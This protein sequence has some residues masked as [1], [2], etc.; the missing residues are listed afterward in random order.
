MALNYLNIPY[1]LTDPFSFPLT[2]FLS[3]WK[4]EANEHYSC[5]HATGLNAPG[6]F[7]TYGGHGN[8]CLLNDPQTKHLIADETYFILDANEPC[9]YGCPQGSTWSF[10]FLH[11]S[12]LLVAR[13]LHLPITKVSRTSQMAFLKGLC[14]RLIQ[15]IIIGSVQNVYEINHLFHALF[16]SLG[17]E[18]E[19]QTGAQRGDVSP[20]LYWMHQNID[21]PL[22]LG[23]LL[24]LCH[25]SRTRFFRLFKDVTGSTPSRY[26]YGL[27][28]E[29]ARVALANS[30]HSLKQIATSLHFYD[31]FHFTTL[32]KKAYGISPSGYRSTL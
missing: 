18:V 7:I 8:L 12:D 16:T 10:Y 30:D 27:K 25:M 19:R 1:E 13:Y 24:N 23:H 32:F 22:D 2:R 5:L 31:E 3:I 21:K 14:E 6:V 28:L 15:N 26:F 4:V 29:S 11:F 20:A 17:A 9:A